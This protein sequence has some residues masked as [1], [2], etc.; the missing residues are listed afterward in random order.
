MGL[1]KPAD[2]DFLSIFIRT[3]SLEG[4]KYF[5]R[6]SWQ[7]K[8]SDIWI[9]FYE[10][11]SRN[12]RY[13]HRDIL[14]K[15]DDDIVWMDLNR[16]AEFTSGVEPGPIYFPSI[17]NNDVG[18]LIQAERGVHENFTSRLLK[19]KH[20][21]KKARTPYCKLTQHAAI[22]TDGWGGDH[23]WF[24]CKS[25]ML[26]SHRIFLN[27]LDAFIAHMISGDR[28]VD[29]MTRIS[30]NMFA[31]TFSTIRCVDNLICIM[32]IRDLSI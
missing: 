24:R 9:S 29:I 30:I 8:R 31:A 15:A 16:F 11:Y 22:L 2:S 12:T 20:L 10:H 18:F 6:P 28:Y 13:G 23:A 26:D 5:S 14:L 32:S 4:Y 25:C 19:N 21:S 7:N 1:E 27:N 3:T 17:V